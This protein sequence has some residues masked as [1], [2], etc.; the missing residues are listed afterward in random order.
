[1]LPSHGDFELFCASG[2]HC[3][4]GVVLQYP[5]VDVSQALDAMVAGEVQGSCILIPPIPDPAKTP[6]GS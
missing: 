4:V 1:M 5:L 3:N 6:H 2:F